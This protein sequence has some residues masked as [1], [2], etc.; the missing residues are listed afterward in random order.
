MLV[1]GLCSLGHILGSVSA[2]TFAHPLRASGIWAVPILGNCEQSSV[3]VPVS[4]QT[5]VVFSSFFSSGFL[6][7]LFYDVHEY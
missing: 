5:L 2:V 7:I 4:G 6:V 1:S 3:G